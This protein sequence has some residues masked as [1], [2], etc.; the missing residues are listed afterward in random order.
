MALP[1]VPSVAE[2][3]SRLEPIP[4]ELDP[5]YRPPTDLVVAQ[6]PGGILAARPGTIANQLA[7]PLDAQAWQVS[8][9]SND[10]ADRPIAA[11]ATLLKLRAG[12][13]K[14]SPRTAWWLGYATVSPVCRTKMPARQR[15]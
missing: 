2:P 8:Y 15:I 13:G 9:R 1:G 10:S 4:P 7:A 12:N 3:E 11:V 14:R 6:R 5:C